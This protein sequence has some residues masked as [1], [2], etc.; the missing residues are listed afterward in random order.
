M[1]FLITAATQGELRKGWQWT[2]GLGPSKNELDKKDVTATPTQDGD[3]P[4]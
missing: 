4:E 1:S 2:D 3:R